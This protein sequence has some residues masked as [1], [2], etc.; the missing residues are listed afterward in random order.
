MRRKT[1]NA[2]SLC[3]FMK[4]LERFWIENGDLPYKALV[5]ARTTIKRE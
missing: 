3:I 4:A 2:S 1:Q 5:S